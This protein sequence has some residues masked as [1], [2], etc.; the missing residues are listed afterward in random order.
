[1]FAAIAEDAHCEIV[2]E[3]HE[4]YLVLSDSS[5]QAVS[6]KHRE[7]NRTQW[8]VSTLVDDGKLGHLFET[9]QRGNGGVQC[10]FETNRSHAVHDLWSD[11]PSK[12]DPLFGDLADRL[13]TD[14]KDLDQ[15]LA[16]FRIDSGLP[17][18]E[19]IA[20]TYASML[21]A[22]ALDRLGL[23][24]DEGIAMRVAG[25]LVAAA[26]EQ[27]LSSDSL[28]KILLANPEERQ[29]VVDAQKISDRRVDSRQ[30]A[31]A[32][33][34]AATD[35]VPRLPLGDANA[36]PPPETTLAKK[37]TKGRLGPSVQRSAGKR[38]ARWY[39]H[40]ARYRDIRHREEELDSVEEWVQ[41]QANVAETEA[42]QGSEDSYGRDMFERLNRTLN[43]R[44]ALPA[45]TRPED[46]NPA[47]LTGAAFELTDSCSIWWSPEFPVDDENP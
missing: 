31:D 46:T 44:D 21:A 15:F 18:K 37:L 27:R 19:F 9:F 10:I 25:D 4:D 38:C 1:L 6:V 24:M 42:I 34:Q 39:A 47:L 29:S 22:P 36:E 33:H 3:W 26:S 5:V 41:D 45:G 13:Q 28:R 43:D 23:N 12:R 32:L 20:A 17:P 30:L 7:Q 11:D 8:T 35:V 14:G 2:C 16:R 40:R